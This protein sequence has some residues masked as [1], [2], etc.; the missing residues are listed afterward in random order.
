MAQ[1]QRP[2][3]IIPRSLEYTA[4]EQGLRPSVL[5]RLENLR[6]LY[7][8]SSSLVLQY[9]QPELILSE[10]LVRRSILAS[11]FYRREHDA[12]IGF[13]YVLEVLS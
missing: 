1:R 9:V 12:C 4:L 11:F 3:L 13:G 10:L 7:M 5:P 8:I 2:P 6:G